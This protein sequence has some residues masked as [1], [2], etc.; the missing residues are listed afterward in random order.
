M[1]RKNEQVQLTPEMLAGM[2]GEAPQGPVEI[3]RKTR[4]VLR[5]QLAV[6]MADEAVPEAGIR[7][8]IDGEQIEPQVFVITIDKGGGTQETLILPIEPPMRVWLEET[9]GKGKGI[10]I[11][12]AA[13]LNDLR[14][15]GG[16]V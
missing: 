6:K 11:A 8:T 16:S 4:V 7:T 3:E 9:F 14:R 5:Y 13:A 10:A 15:N 12:P 2:I 1:R